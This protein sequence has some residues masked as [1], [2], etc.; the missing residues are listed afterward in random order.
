MLKYSGN[1]SCGQGAEGIRGRA[2]AGVRHVVVSCRARSLTRYFAPMVRPTSCPFCDLPS[3]SIADESAHAVVLR[4]R[5]PVAPGHALV[6]PRRHV[7]SIFDLEQE[8][9]DD[10]WRL[11]RRVRWGIE[12]LRTADGVNVGVNVGVAAGQTVP[13][14]HVHLIPRNTGDVPDAR[15][16]V[17]RLIPEKA[18]YWSPRS[19]DEGP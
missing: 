13:H 10:L 14:A 19:S 15:G 1:V 16:G 11:V 4:D 5:F 2:S 8:E 3:D 18:D 12:E 7:E 9:W 17:R 6:V